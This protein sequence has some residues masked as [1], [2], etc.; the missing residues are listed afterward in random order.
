MKKRNAFL[1]TLS[2][3]LVLSACLFV[4]CTGRDDTGEESSS[5]PVSGTVS[6][7]AS[8][9]IDVAVFRG[10]P[11]LSEETD[12][13]ILHM[14]SSENV[15]KFFQSFFDSHAS[16]KDA[17]GTALTAKELAKK[18]DMIYFSRCD[19][20]ILIL[21]GDADVPA[22]TLEDSVLCADGPLTLPQADSET[23]TYVF[24]S[25]KRT[26]P[27][28]AIT[29]LRDEAGN[30]VTETVYTREALLAP[31]AASMLETV[32]DSIYDQDKVIATN[33]HYW[34]AERMTYG[35]YIDN[36]ATTSVVYG[37]VD[38]SLLPSMDAP[39]TEEPKEEPRETG[40]VATSRVLEGGG[41]VTN[42]VLPSRNE[43][44]YTEDGRMVIEDT[45]MW[46]I[47]YSEKAEPQ[48]DGG[49]TVVFKFLEDGTSIAKA[50]ATGT[51][52][53]ET[54]PGASDDAED[55]TEGTG[56]PLLP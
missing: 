27:G 50:Y 24:V 21:D 31:E 33:Y 45:R 3:I 1:L 38:K 16:F 13:Y 51:S 18:F 23:L 7:P 2:L 9:S 10:T 34:Y 43:L 44:L 4:S 37:P 36:Y 29:A 15:R 30:T 39:P 55:K 41:I 5:A 47:V 46:F 8:A 53:T 25:I 17:E 56:V 12:P 54:R 42:H 35:V 14:T 40:E 20:Y 22:F 11:L 48:Y 32:Y 28:F 52:A 49:M 19:C 6:P 26:R